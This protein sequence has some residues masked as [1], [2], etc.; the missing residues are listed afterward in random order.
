[1]KT[2]HIMCI[3]DFDRFMFCKTKNIFVRV[4][5]SA[6][7]VKMYWHSIKKFVWALMVQICKIRKKEVKMLLMNLLKQFLKSMNTFTK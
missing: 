7:V 5:Y 3:K 4:I 6:L 1:M 2:S